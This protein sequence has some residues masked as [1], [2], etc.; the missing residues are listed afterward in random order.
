[1]AHHLVGSLGAFSVS[2]FKHLVLQAAGQRHNTFFFSI[3]AEVFFALALGSFV[4]LG[5]LGALFF[6]LSAEEI[7]HNLLCFCRRNLGFLAVNHV[8]YSLCK[9]GN[10]QVV[11]THLRQL[12]ANA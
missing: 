2:L 4:L 1:M 11:R 5:G 10:V 6:F 3:L 9:V 7:F 12:A 8:L